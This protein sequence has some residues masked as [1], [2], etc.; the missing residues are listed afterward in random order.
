MV[1]NTVAITQNKKGTKTI[2]L[3]ELF[4]QNSEK[5]QL[6]IEYTN[7]PDWMMIQ[8]LPAIST[9]INKDVLSVAAAF[10]RFFY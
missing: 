7:N 8:A 4:P 6:T 10:Q 2:N 1:T 5:Q 9:P 3:K